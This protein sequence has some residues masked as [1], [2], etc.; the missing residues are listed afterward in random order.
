MNDAARIRAL[1]DE[2]DTLRE[3][4]AEAERMMAGYVLAWPECLRLTPAEGRVLGAL[5]RGRGLS[6]EY[7][8]VCSAR[9]GVLSEV[10]RG[11]GRVMISRLRCKVRPH[12]VMIKTVRSVGWIL[13]GESLAQVRAWAATGRIDA[14]ADDIAPEGAV[15]RVAGAH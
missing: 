15:V 4:L 9:D 13:E 8:R 7:A 10:D 3:A 5:M 12:G 14:T 6:H 1:E 2:N 11:S